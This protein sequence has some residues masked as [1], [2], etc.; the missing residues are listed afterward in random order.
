MI[1]SLLTD[2]ITTDLDRAVHYALLW[3]L[4]GVELRSVGGPADR[5]PFVNESKLRYR[6]QESELP[7][8]AVVP[9]IFEGRVDDRSTWLN[10]V[11][12]LDET[13]QFCRRINCPRV[14][15][16]SFERGGE[17]GS[18][19]KALRA[20]G[21][22]AGRYGIE[23]CVIN[24]VG[25]SAS[26]GAELARLVSAAGNV[27]AAWSPAAALESGEDVVEGLEA[28]KG[29]I[30]I[31]RCRNGAVQGNGWEPRSIDRG[32]IDWPGQVRKLAD[33]GFDGPISLEVT[34]DQ[35]AKQGLHD[36]TAIIQYIRAARRG[37]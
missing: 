14:V 9:G 7:V 12:S 24:E 35:P 15:V 32:E 34:G 4:E 17:E 28:L 21:E 37:T 13:L 10:E 16:S 5:V 33:G 1:P 27:L 22:R 8:V 3:G 2:T 36:A 19:V 23:I 6:L 25:M 26:T 11:A 20:A 18:T 29:S 31:V 30:A